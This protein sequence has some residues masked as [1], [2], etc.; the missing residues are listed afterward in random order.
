[1]SAPQRINNRA[2]A[3]HGNLGPIGIYRNDF[4]IGERQENDYLITDRIIIKVNN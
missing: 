4:V 3:A 2:V 1:M